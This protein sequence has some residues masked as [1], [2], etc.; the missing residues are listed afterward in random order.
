MLSAADGESVDGSGPAAS[1][2]DGFTLVSKDVFR[3][4]VKGT[5]RNVHPT[6]RGKST[7]PDGF[8]DHWHDLHSGQLVGLSTSKTGH[9]FLHA[10]LA[11]EVPALQSI[12]ASKVESQ[13]L[14]SAWPVTKA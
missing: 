6:P 1:V 5:R 4:W 11:D 7:D 3:A 8:I 13:S 2:P 9:H 12:T 14:G 10:C